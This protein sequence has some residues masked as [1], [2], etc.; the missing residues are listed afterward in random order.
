MSD[1]RVAEEV[2]ARRERV[3]RVIAFLQ[4]SRAALSHEMGQ[5]A[6]AIQELVAELQ[7]IDRG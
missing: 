5:L 6:D 4:E 3:V 2:A 7:E 1:N